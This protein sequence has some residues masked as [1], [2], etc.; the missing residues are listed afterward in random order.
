MMLTYH[1]R[2]L[3]FDHWATIVS[4]DAVEPVADRVPR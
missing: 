2:M 4:L 1:R 3:T